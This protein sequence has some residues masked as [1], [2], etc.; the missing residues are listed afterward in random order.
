M[1]F[2]L[3]K[4]ELIFV[5]SQILRTDQFVFNVIMDT[6]SVLTREN[7]SDASMILI[8]LVVDTVKL[9]ELT[10]QSNSVLNVSTIW[11]STLTQVNANTPLVLVTSELISTQT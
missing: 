11:T 6:H 2:A 10:D 8:S 1:E 4:T 5:S 3:K 9:T 7:V